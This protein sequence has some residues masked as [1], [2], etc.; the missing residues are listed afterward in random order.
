MR[1]EEFTG[2]ADSADADAN[3]ERVRPPASLLVIA[4]FCVGSSGTLLV[5]P[6]LLTHV[7]GY[8]LGSVVTIA[9]VGV[10]RRTDVQRRQHP[11]YLP[12]GA[13]TRYAGVIVP[14]GLAVAA[15]HT[16]SI[17]TELAK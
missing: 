10:F 16:W 1:G 15:V 4:A 6:G 9:L 14:L 12:R 3:V 8:A 13:L 2:G 11:L 5:L 17:A 7:V